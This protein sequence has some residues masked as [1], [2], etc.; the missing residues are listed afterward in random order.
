MAL[1]GL[2]RIGHDGQWWF[3]GTRRAAL[4]SIL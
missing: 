3:I 1:T 2:S 4:V